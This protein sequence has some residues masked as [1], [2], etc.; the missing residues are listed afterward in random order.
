MILSISELIIQLAN[1]FSE[2]TGTPEGISL[3]A[4]AIIAALGGALVSVGILALIWRYKALV[5]RNRQV[6]FAKVFIPYIPRIG[7]LSALRIPTPRFR[8]NLS[9][10]RGLATSVGI[11]AV[12]FSLALTTVVATSDHTP[13]FP[14]AGAEY[15]L[16]K[17]FGTPL[18]P[19]PEY[20]SQQSQTLQLNLGDNSRLDKL[21][22][23]NMSLGKA[24]LDRCVDITYA[25]TGVASSAYLFTGKLSMLNVSAP[26]FVTT[27]AEISQLN[28]AG[29]IDGSSVTPTQD[30]TVPELVVNSDRG[31]GTFE[32]KDSTVDRIVIKVTGSPKV[33]EIIFKNV[34]CSV[35]EWYISN[36]KA[37]EM[38]QDAD[39]KFGNGTGID[40]PSYSVSP[41]VKIRGGSTSGLVD[42]PINVR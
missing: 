32:S 37:G 8:F 27:G 30:S 33:G 36:V 25:S 4:S 12:G 11:V 26:T 13:I 40:V 7:F 41:G 29:S 2:S 15:H 10:W 39:S 24:G 42:R 21:A 19:D 23:E 3:F 35:G 22:F 18:E 16:P 20:P 14:E 34:H 17:V 6:Q 5:V 38:V 1:W 9:G 28:L 31:A